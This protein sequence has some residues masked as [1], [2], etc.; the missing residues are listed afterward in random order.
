MKFI[1]FFLLSFFVLA[2]LVPQPVLAQADVYPGSGG[3][4]QPNPGGS[5]QPSSGGIQSAEFKLVDPLGDK[6]FC[7]LV[8]ALLDIALAVGI[9]VAVFFLV[10]AGFMFIFARGN[11]EKLRTAK[12]NFMYVILGIVLFL[13]AWTF[14]TIVAATVRTLDSGGNVQLCD[15]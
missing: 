15:R 10:W 9:P 6:N 2:T 7:Q 8:K 14:A 1:K 11:E 3:Q 5:I 12:R 13:G 4:I